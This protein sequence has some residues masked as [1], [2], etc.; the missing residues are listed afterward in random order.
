MEENKLDLLTIYQLIADTPYSFYIPSYQRGYRWTIQQVTDLLDDILEF[1]V[2][3]RPGE[4][5]CL[6][7]IVVK[8]KEQSW[9]VIDGQQ[10]LTTI[11][12][13]LKYFNSRLTEEFRKPLYQLKYE[14]RAESSNYLDTL[15][16]NESKKN[17]DYFH[18]YQAY[19][20]IK[21]WFATRS[22]IIN[23]F[24]ATL[25][26]L[27]KVI[28]YEVHED[29]DSIDIFTRLNIGKIPLNPAELI[30]ALFLFRDNFTGNDQ[31]KQLRQL[32]IAGEWDR[33]EATLRDKEFW[34]FINNK[35]SYDNHIEF[36]FDLMSNKTNQDRDYTFRYFHKRFDKI[37]DVE[38][39]WKEVKNYFLTFQEW[40]NDKDLFHLIGFLITVGEKIQTIKAEGKNK[41]K[42]E[43]KDHLRSMV[44]KN[45][46]VQV[47]ELSYS[48]TSDRK[49]IRNLLLLFNLISITNNR[50]ANYKFQFGRYK[51][52]NWD[53]EHIH[54]V[55]SSMPER[56]EH[57]REWLNEVLAY[58]NNQDLKRRINVWMQT[59]RKSRVDTFEN[60]YDDVLREY[61]ENKVI[62]D[63]NDISNL[64]LLDASTNRG[65]KNAI[66]PIKRNKIIER[67][68]SGTF[69][70]LCTKNVFLKYYNRSVKGMTL[71][72]SADRKSYIDAITFMLRDY[73]PIQ[74]SNNIQS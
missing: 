67:D 65:Y 47:S 26:N 61:S 25:L 49:D 22:N 51:A 46:N 57:Q 18:I 23:D 13:L 30:K 41:T 53:L 29:T 58:T 43:F 71:W 17:V 45:V 69:I 2:N 14:T 37:N 27:V 20:T 54:S 68:Q 16:E 8:P 12:L 4:F 62:D 1:S 40:Y 10:R 35:D 36:I 11:F 70:P 38:E 7:P 32:E 48:D 21:N 19:T 60:I 73:L 50:E 63:I 24:E 59:D 5:Y 34:G 39:A 6:Q 74:N 55:K 3:K 31:T 72:N 64:T 28:W 33:I 56:E 15:S 66:F 44:K 52:E 42:I 9:E